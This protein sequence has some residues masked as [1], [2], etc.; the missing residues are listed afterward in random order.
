[1]K[2]AALSKYWITEKQ[3][4]SIVQNT[5]IMAVYTILIWKTFFLKFGIK[6]IRRLFPYSISIPAFGTSLNS[7]KHFL[8]YYTPILILNIPGPA[9][10]RILPRF[11]SVTQPQ[12]YLREHAIRHTARHLLTAAANA[13]FTFPSSQRNGCIPVI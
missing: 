6:T 5:Q 3:S 4:V 2:C 1:M 11:I 13:P 8:P 7:N 12:S 10:Y 9:I